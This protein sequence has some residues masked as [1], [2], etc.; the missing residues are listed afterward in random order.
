M[1][2]MPFR[3]RSAIMLLILLGVTVASWAG[4][5]V[6]LYLAQDRLIFQP[7]HT[8]ASVPTAIGLDYEDIFLQTTDNQRLHAWYV[9][10]EDAKG[11]VLFLHGNA[12]NVSHR[13][14]SLQIFN[15]LDMSTLIID[16]RGYGDS[17]GTPSEQGTY[18]DAETAW[19]YLTLERGIDAGRI[20]IFGRSLGGAVAAWLGA[21]VE[22]AGI[23]MESAFVS[24]A[25]LAK[26][27][28]PYM[29]VDL[30]LHSRYPTRDY[31]AAINAPTLL[32]HSRED[33]L[34]P[35]QH[36]QQLQQAGN[37][38][39]ELQAIQGGHND[40]FVLTGDQ[41]IEIVRQFKEKVIN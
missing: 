23:I 7:T 34:I 12:G 29:P 36:A 18:K 28:Y 37:D 33:E 15:R 13:L 40:G 31:M 41:Y 2:R 22:P 38:H 1:T 19:N 32:I 4:F 27:Y 35:F 24:L 9:A 10:A 3:G 30:L 11:V 16:Y 14:A 26:Q 8:L 6:I 25:S 20:I 21:R 39:V 5:A 17:E